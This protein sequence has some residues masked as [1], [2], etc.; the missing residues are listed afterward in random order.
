VK[1]A[2]VVAHAGPLSSTPP[3]QVSVEQF[4]PEN[5]LI[6]LSQT[7]PQREAVMICPEPGITYHT[8]G[9]VWE[10]PQVAF[11]PVPEFVALIV[12]P[13]NV[14]PQVIEVALHTKS[15]GGTTAGAEHVKAKLNA[16]VVEY[17]E[18]FI[19]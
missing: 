10:V 19:Q 16:L 4:G 3:T 11:S 8:P 15:F 14:A 12:V 9:I 5:T 18:T 7:V 17:P 13:A 1:D 6:L 2:D